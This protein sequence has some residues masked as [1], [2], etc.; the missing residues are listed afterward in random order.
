MKLYSD[1]RN[2]VIILCDPIIYFKHKTK[3]PKFDDGHVSSFDIFEMWDSE[4][5]LI[6]LQLDLFPNLDHIY[7]VDSYKR[8]NV[9]TK[10]LTDN[11]LIN[12]VVSETE[13]IIVTKYT[14][15][16]GD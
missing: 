7:K 16:R 13:K 12:A 2:K 11:D 14:I 4:A 10:Y 6:Q 15:F 1:S 9:N 3:T 8:N 5:A